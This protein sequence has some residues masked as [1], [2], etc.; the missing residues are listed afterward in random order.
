MKSKFD[1]HCL[2]PDLPD[3][4]EVSAYLQE[5]HDNRWYTNFGPLNTRFEASMVDFFASH[6]SPG[7]SA[8]TFSSATTGLELILKAMQLPAGGRVLIPALTFPAT[9]LAV[10]NAGLEP[11][12]GDVDPASWELTAET[13]AAAHTVRPLV[14]AMPVAAFGRPIAMQDWQGFQRDTGVPVVVDAAAALGQQQVPDEL[15][16]V[17]SLHATKPFGVGEG[18]LAVSG[19]AELLL[20]AKS[21]SNFGF[22]GGA[23]KVQHTGTNAKLGEYYAAVGLVQL[24]RFDEIL[25]RRRS[26]AAMYLESLRL[27]GN[28]IRMQAGIED[29][30]PAVFPVFAAGKGQAIANAMAGAAIQTR[31]WYLPLLHKHPALRGLNFAMSDRP[32]SLPVCNELEDGLVGLPFHA[33]L[34]RSDIE[35]ICNILVGIL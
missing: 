2:V 13:A 29:F 21:L 17:F 9:A 14:A 24:E 6:G 27:L 10:M 31:H 3:P 11:V 34:S 18:G 22:R 15:T 16:A 33:F 23:G 19:D 32:D 5:M 30:V 7:L 8:Q 35:R 28:K 25:E 20:R 4:S 26:V 12:L 1:I